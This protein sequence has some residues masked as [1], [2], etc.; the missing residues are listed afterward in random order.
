LQGVSFRAGWWSAEA[1]ALRILDSCFEPLPAFALSLLQDFERGETG[2]VVEPSPKRTKMSELPSPLQP[3]EEPDDAEDED[4]E[5]T[6]AVKTIDLSS[7]AATGK[8]LP[9]GTSFPRRRSLNRPN[10]VLSALPDFAEDP[11]VAAMRQERRLKRQREEEEQ[12]REQEAQAAEARRLY[13]ASIP[14]PEP[15]APTT[16]SGGTSRVVANPTG[17]LAASEVIASLRVP[18]LIGAA[19]ETTVLAIP[20]PPH[21]SEPWMKHPRP[22]PAVDPWFRRFLPPLLR[23]RTLCAKYPPP[24]ER[25]VGDSVLYVATNTPRLRDNWALRIALWVANILNAPLIA[26]V[27][28]D[29]RCLS[30]T[31]PLST[32]AALGAWV[33]FAHS[34]RRRGCPAC[35]VL[36]PQDASASTLTGTLAA[37]ATSWNAHC[38]V[39]D[40]PSCVQEEVVVQML[41]RLM[42]GCPVLPVESS[43]GD[44][45]AAVALEHTTVLDD[46][47]S[48]VDSCILPPSFAAG[49]WSVS[50]EMPLVPMCYSPKFWA[51]AQQLLPAASNT[52]TELI[53]SVIPDPQWPG[54][55]GVQAARR[56]V[57]S[58]EA[59][60]PQEEHDE[61]AVPLGV[62]SS[63]NDDS[64]D[65]FPS[66]LSVSTASW[67]VLA[68]L[69]AEDPKCNVSEQRSLGVLHMERGWLRQFASSLQ[70]MPL[71]P[72]FDQR[73]LGVLLR[74]ELN[75]QGLTTLL[76]FTRCGSLSPIFVLQSLWKEAEKLVGP[77]QVCRG[78]NLYLQRACVVLLVM[79]S[80]PRLL[81]G[82]SAKAEAKAEPMRE[83]VFDS[84]GEELLKAV[85]MATGSMVLGGW[86]PDFCDRFEGEGL[87]PDVVREAPVTEGSPETLESVL[88]GEDSPDGEWNRVHQCLREH[89]EV[90]PTLFALWAQRIFQWAADLPRALQIATELL[91]RHSRSS[92]AA[93]M[94]ALY[95]AV[96]FMGGS[97]SVLKGHRGGCLGQCESTVLEEVLGTSL[98]SHPLL[99]ERLV[100]TT[101]PTEL[102]EE[103]G[104]LPLPLVA[105][106]ILDAL[107]DAS[108]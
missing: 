97:D 70:E 58:D 102:E 17:F 26:V 22:V 6:P 90:P 29:E 65:L 87:I 48:R 40:A 78:L 42:R 100:G 14:R 9:G 39:M 92:E 18:A 68:S 108:E 34:L 24:S 103:H 27:P 104:A 61:R 41:S 82:C 51:V 56:L 54:E 49:L 46:A 75:G 44:Q 88:C 20:C 79:E 2:E 93:H 13:E 37:L 76:S 16:L 36:I 38:I 53:Y 66:A 62:D 72:K 98:G 105:Q 19:S 67:G 74:R 84:R 5:G 89:G 1:V 52:L 32:S 83:A 86:A 35:P 60:P 63:V 107:I 55:Q 96:C 4:E 64:M 11:A 50:L 8:L 15:R 47:L 12:R 101:K 95:C 7:M 73:A 80:F 30:P 23:R 28:I 59:N 77:P 81:V 69:R 43:A 21:S 31:R 106:S 85:G 10:R 3:Q 71:D 99:A 91:A 33:P 57:Q 94:G 25:R 45:L